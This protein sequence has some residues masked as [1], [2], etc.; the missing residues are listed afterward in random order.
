MEAEGAMIQIMMRF[1]LYEKNEIIVNDKNTFFADTLNLND[2]IDNNSISK[3][4]RCDILDY[5]WLVGS[6]WYS[7][8]WYD[9]KNKFIGV[10]VVFGKNILYGWIKIAIGPDVPQGLPPVVPLVLYEYACTIGYEN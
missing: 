9:Q 4:S 6:S 8:L 3:N 5:N 10:K 1:R 2:V 7:G